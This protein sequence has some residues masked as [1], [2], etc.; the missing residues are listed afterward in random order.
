MQGMEMQQRAYAGDSLD[1]ERYERAQDIRDE[2]TEKSACKSDERGFGNKDVANIL[3]PCADCTENTDFTSAFD[4][5]VGRDDA[6]HDGGYDKRYC[7]NRYEHCGHEVEYSSHIDQKHFGH[8]EV[9]YIAFAGILPCGN[10]VAGIG[11]LI[12]VVGIY[13]DIIRTSIM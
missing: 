13:R 1:D 11:F 10:I 5:G 9:A 6:D 12:A 7:G 3:L 4:N 2:Y 8:I